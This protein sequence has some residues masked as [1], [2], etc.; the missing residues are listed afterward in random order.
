MHL[1]K[2]ENYRRG[3]ISSSLFNVGGKSVAF[4]QQWLI[5]FYFGTHSDTDVFFFTYNIILFLSYFF[6]NFTTAV[7]IPEGMKIRVR[8]SDEKSKQ[9][10]NTYIQFYVVVGALL[11]LLSLF[12]TGRVFAFISEF[13]TEVIADNITLIRW[14]LPIIFLNIVVTI[15]SEILASYK[16]FTAPNLITLVNYVCGVAFIVLFHDSLGINVVALG[17]IVGYVVN[18]VIFTCFMRKLL[19]WEFFIRPVGRVKSILGSSIYAQVGHA[20]YL[21]ALYVPQNLFSQLPSGTLTAINFA[22]KLISIPSIFLVAQITN[23]MAIKINNLVS[24]NQ[25]SELSRLIKRLMTSVSAGLA[26]VA[27]GIF[28]LSDP[29]IDLLF[30]WGNY[31]MSA[32]SI[33]ARILSTMIFFLPFSF[34][35][36]MYEKVFNSLKKQSYVFYMQLFTQGLMLVLYFCIIPRFGLFSYSA[37][38][39]V[40]YVIATAFASCV[41]ALM[42]HNKAI[43]WHILACHFLITIVAAIFLA[44]DWY[45][46]GWV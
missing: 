5:G 20:V 38:R 41:S 13:P 3:I 14:C 11:V 27:I 29:I 22:N 43:M 9:F 25:L 17:L 8:E 37:C 42:L 33:T 1:L 35:F 28:L 6:L 36:A 45:K 46:F 31:D 23:V 19:K 32:M 12:D 2:S 44:V 30:S 7:L 40:P 21:V 15:M 4:L 24:S 26:I 18:L 16:Y 10:L 34:M 39:I